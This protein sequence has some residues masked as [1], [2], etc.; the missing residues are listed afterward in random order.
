MVLMA[1]PSH[2]ENPTIKRGQWERVMREMPAPRRSYKLVALNLATYARWDGTNARPSR[3]RIA[4]DTGL[5]L[6]S[7]SY[8][9]VWLRGR[10]W[11]TEVEQSRHGVHGRL[12]TEYR[13][14]FPDRLPWDD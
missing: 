1:V 5:S 6:R 14:T 3:E 8:A 12:A 4:A 11:I 7:V 10:R 13:L 9:M 2:G